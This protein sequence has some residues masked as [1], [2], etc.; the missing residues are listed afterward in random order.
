MRVKSL[1]A[2]LAFTAM[3][4]ALLFGPAGFSPGEPQSAEA[5]LFNEIKKLLASDAQAGEHFSYRSVAV[6]GDTAIVGAYAADPGGAAYIFQR[7]EGGADNWGQVKILTASDAA[8]GLFGRSVAV[9]GD[10]AI[11]GANGAGVGGAAYIFQRN[12]GGADN[13]GEVKILTASDAQVADFFGFSVAVSGDIALIGA[14]GEDG[15]AGDPLST[16]GASYV[17]QRNEGGADNWGQVKVLTAAVRAASDNFGWSG[18][19]SGDIAV[20]GTR[21]RESAHVF[22]R[23]KGGANNWGEVK[24]LTA[25][26]AGTSDYFG[27]SVAVN[28]DTAVVGATSSALGGATY[29]FG[30]DEGGADNWG[31]VTK[32]T[33]SDAQ[34]GDRFGHSVAVSGNI[35]V[36][37]AAKDALG[38]MIPDIF[39]AAYLF[40]RNEGGA[41]NWGE[42][43]K[44]TASD[45][46][47]GDDFGNSVAVS[48]AFAVV[49][50]PGE[51]AG[52]TDAGAAY[53]FDL[54]QPEST[55]TPTPTPCPEGKVPANGG[56]GTPTPTPTNTPTPTATPT[57]TPCDGPC[58]TPTPTPEAS[59]TVTTTD[60][61][62]NSD[63]D[64]SL[65]EAIQ[66][67]NTD[68]AVDACAAGSGADT[69]TVPAGIYTLTAGDL[70]VTTDLTVNGAGAATTIV[71]G[72]GITRIFYIASG[73]TVEI[74]GLTIRNGLDY[75]A[76]GG[77]HNGGTLTLN[78][79]IVSGN[80]VEGNYDAGGINN[81]GTLTLNNTTVN[82]NTANGDYSTGGIKNP[83]GRTLNLNNS[84]VSGN[85]ATGDYSTGGIESFQ[86]A[87]ATLNN[88]TVSGNSA[89]GDYG[90]GGIQNSQSAILNL[91][92]ITVSGNSAI[93]NYGTGGIESYQ[94]A[95]ATLNNSTV[96]GNSAT[97]NYGT[98][99]IQNFQS[100]I[101]ILNNSTVS[102]NTTSS[103]IG[104]DIGGIETY[105]FAT[106]TLKNTIIANNGA[107]D[108]NGPV[109]SG[110]YNLDSDGSCG[111]TGLGDISNAN[112]LLGP[113]TNNGG[114]T[115]THALL[116]GSPAIDAGSGDCP[117]PITDQRGVIRPAGSAC[118]IGAFEVGLLPTPGPTATPTSTATPC[119]EGKVP[120]NGGCGTPTPT[121]DLT[122]TDGDG[123]R[124]QKESGLDETLG[125]MR[126]PLIPWDY[127]DVAG[128]SG[129]TPDGYIDLLFDILGVIQ[130]YSPTGDPPYDAHY[131]RGPMSGPNPWNMTAPDGS[132]D[133]LNDILGVIQQ[134]GHDC[135]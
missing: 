86:S 92:N 36:I 8:G 25:F 24:T 3:A 105:Q 32:L 2:L 84:T 125:G 89:I 68:T 102:D 91:N 47:A 9:S 27:F 82:D 88:S 19:V 124:D 7:N 123:C 20:V 120:A 83:S 116:A 117:P 54:L 55:A 107:S 127:Y 42:V 6:N 132:I 21:Y 4:A 35:A 16:A 135:R 51:D 23:D 97:G 43:M 75:E 13:W 40:E 30:R 112:P 77:I 80:S 98:G 95:S 100:A 17:Y 114:T 72:S 79:S 96:S 126:D 33:A 108:C 10:T 48:G 26:D 131:D 106:V 109:I 61:E 128:M 50:A 57:A 38:G 5:A 130:H 119:P 101:L 52:G 66:A 39:G 118:D 22:Q 11:M 78:D 67:A 113:L 49:G 104:N 93:G 44:L 70:N 65:R 53:V 81:A 64:C 58:P 99:G 87:S 134:H 111:L 74:S 69:I 12:E 115:E 63:G 15:G 60:D 56:C 90:T 1:L 45:P 103:A 62:L 71:D 129:A 121:P 110:G 94:S 41:D 28:G 34:A 37:G 85:I 73:A 46:Q 29:V 76:A 18:S 31:E 59:F 122:D 133:L 14:F